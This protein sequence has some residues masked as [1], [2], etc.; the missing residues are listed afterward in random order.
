MTR[1]SSTSRISNAC[2]TL[3]MKCFQTEMSVREKMIVMTR[4]RA[5]TQNT[6]TSASAA[7]RALRILT[8]MGKHVQVRILQFKLRYCYE[9]PINF[10][11][12][13]LTKFSNRIA[14]TWQRS[15]SGY[16]LVPR[17][18]H[19]AVTWEALGTRLIGLQL[20]LNNRWFQ[21]LTIIDTAKPIVRALPV[22]TLNTIHFIIER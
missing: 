3:T 21:S 14:G 16:N 11:A 1:L 9:S 6:A 13:L 18:S 2:F 5:E 8:E 20:V 22:A 17:V 10:P 7:R 15:Q 12:T 19:L 4:R